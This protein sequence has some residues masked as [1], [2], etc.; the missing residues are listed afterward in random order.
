MTN[1]AAGKVRANFNHYVY[2]KMVSPVLLFTIVSYWFQAWISIHSSTFNN[3]DN[4][5]ISVIVISNQC[6]NEHSIMLVC[7]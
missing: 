6:H 1:V 7:Q 4:D 5:K 2:S 3:N